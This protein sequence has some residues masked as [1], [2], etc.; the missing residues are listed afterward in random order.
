MTKG[1][2]AMTT[3]TLNKVFLRGCARCHGDLFLDPVGD[4]YTCLQCGRTVPAARIDAAA[5]IDPLIA[6]EMSADN[7]RLQL[8]PVQIQEVTHDAA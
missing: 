2:A 7:R 6:R 4:E 3:A 8:M 1:M 5:R